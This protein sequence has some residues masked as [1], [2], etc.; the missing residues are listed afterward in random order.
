MGKLLNLQDNKAIYVHKVLNN[1]RGDD[2]LWR[3]M[4]SN[5]YSVTECYKTCVT[6]KMWI[7]QDIIDRMLA[8][9]G[10]G[11]KIISNNGSYFCCGFYVNG[12]RDTDYLIVLTYANTYAVPVPKIKNVY[13][14]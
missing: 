2:F 14:D 11:Y 3:H 4:H 5:K 12:E 1:A 9:D 7:E 6:R 10:Y 8:L 13:V